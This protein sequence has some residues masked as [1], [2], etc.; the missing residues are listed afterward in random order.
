MISPELF[1]RFPFFAPF[2]ENDLKEMALISEEFQGVKG[3][4]LFEECQPANFLFLL[5]EGGVDLSY[6]SEETFHPKTS[7]EF[8]VGEI[9]PGEVFGIS[10]LIEPYILS[11]TARLSQDSKYIT[12]EANHLRKMIEGNHHLGY[13]LLQQ[14]SKVLMERLAYTR[15]QLAA[16][17]AN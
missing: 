14:I 15:V 17:W 10:S 13:L 4:Q 7:K 2:S 16:A 9:N 5:L 8:P 3:D 6:K 1:R 11:A 12:I